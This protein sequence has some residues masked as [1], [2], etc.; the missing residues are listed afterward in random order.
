MQANPPTWLA[1]DMLD[2]LRNE[3]SG[4]LFDI[5]SLALLI[6]DWGAPNMQG[7]PVCQIHGNPPAHQ[8]NT[9][10]SEYHAAACCV[11]LMHAVVRGD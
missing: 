10:K 11:R 1:G 2:V 3:Q 5:D 4:D 7:E 6:D 9:R 8:R